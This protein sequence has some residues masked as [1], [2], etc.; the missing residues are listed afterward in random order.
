M[1][2][3]SRF[4]ADFLG[5][6]NIYQGVLTPGKG[7][8]ALDIDGLVIL[9]PSQASGSVQACVRPED[10]LVSRKPIESDAQNA[11]K[12]KIVDVS[13]TGPVVNIQV[14]VGSVPFIA[15]ITRR[16][17]Y[18]MELSLGD[19]VFVTFKTVDVHVF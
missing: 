5:V 9:T 12:G 4:A 18:D 2:P 17:F 10:I 14:D 1:K 15:A 7:L 13:N 11:F 16:S 8:S 6:S 19:D 3:N